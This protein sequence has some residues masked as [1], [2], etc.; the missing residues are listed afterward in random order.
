MW[1]GSKN[2]VPQDIGDLV[3]KSPAIA[4]DYALSVSGAPI[5]NLHS[6]TRASISAYIHTHLLLFL[7]IALRS[8]YHIDLLQQLC[9]ISS[10][11]LLLSQWE[12]FS[13]SGAVWRC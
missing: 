8:H 13:N 6:Y 5:F 9:H 4:R 2:R 3:A 10:F 7:Q 11:R 12:L 1:E